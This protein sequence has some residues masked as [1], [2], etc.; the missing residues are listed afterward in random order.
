MF[1]LF[2]FILF[3][4]ISFYKILC[5]NRYLNVLERK[6]R[7]NIVK[8]QSVIFSSKPPPSANENAVIWQANKGPTMRHIIEVSYPT[9]S[10]RYGSPCQKKNPQQNYN[11]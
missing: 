8:D 2:Y 9:F 5:I 6:D 10:T 1:I 11:Q 3:H 7:D 4:F